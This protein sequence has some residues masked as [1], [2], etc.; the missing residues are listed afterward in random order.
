MS[1][2]GEGDDV[3]VPGLPPIEDVNVDAEVPNDEE[4]GKLQQSVY[5]AAKEAQVQGQCCQDTT[6]CSFGCGWGDNR[7]SSL[8]L[9]T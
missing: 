4:R 7:N 2:G 8:L 6:C 5:V 1:K 9:S 3:V